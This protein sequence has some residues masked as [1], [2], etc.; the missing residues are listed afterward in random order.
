[1]FASIKQFYRS[2][3][4]TLIALAA[5]SVF[6]VLTAYATPPGS[7]YTAGATLDPACAP[8]DTNCSVLIIPDQTG[9]SGEYLT[10][11]GTTLSWASVPGGS[12]LIGSTSASGSGETWLGY[13]AGTGGSASDTVFI[14]NDAGGNATSATN[15]VFVG[16]GAGYLATNAQVSNFIGS[17]AGLNATNAQY[18]NFIGS[19]AGKNA[20][21]AFSS[22]FIGDQ[23]GY[24]AANATNSVFIGKSAG[25]NVASDNTY[26][27]SFPPAYFWSVFIGDSAGSA[28]TDAYRSVFIGSFS[29]QNAVNASESV[30]IGEQAGAGAGNATYSIAIGKKA[31]FNA[32]NA[33]EATFIGAFSGNTA[34]N[35]DNSTMLGFNAGNGATNAAN[36]IFI[37]YEAGLSDTVDNTGGSTSILIGNSTATGGFVDS[38]ALGTGATNT[39][40]NQFMI[41]ST[42]RPIDITRWNGSAS[43]QCTLTTGTGIAC[44]SDERL[45]E[46]ITTLGDDTLSKLRNI[47]TVTFT[48][49]NALSDTTQIGFIAQNL[50]QYFPQ[51]VATDTDGYKSV[52]YAQMT[53]IL[54]KALQE[55]DSKVD[56]LAGLDTATS[57]MES[58]A[59]WLADAANGIQKLFA[60]EIETTTLCVADESGAKTC[61]TKAQLDTL[62][63]Q[64]QEVLPP[65]DLQKT[66]PE[67][68]TTSP[69]DETSN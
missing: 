21:N 48:W 69:S 13:G 25:L 36:S 64:Q 27:T 17:Q 66:T 19:Q 15:A 28:A 34:A 31:G 32:T 62:L 18:S 22:N 41:G 57:F 5:A 10:T 52:Y 53:P 23:A 35:A 63:G 39:A 54:T 37:G 40:S 44:T 6:S 68:I 43:T 14:G 59:A 46:N 3:N 61:I 7:P 47:D 56:A 4:K 29:G 30:F 49:K 8:G 50:E 55:L 20:L 26:S 38:I 11:N 67:E 33:D 60:K 2:H 51:L 16:G 12:S 45:K 24:G 9:N 65:Q 42:T 1:M 58:I